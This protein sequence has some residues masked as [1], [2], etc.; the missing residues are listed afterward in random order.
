[1]LLSLEGAT[2]G[3][4]RDK[5]DDVTCLERSAT[6]PE[7]VDLDVSAGVG[8]KAGKG[9]QYPHDKFTGTK[10]SRA[11]I[12]RLLRPGLLG[13]S[14]GPRSLAI[15]KADLLKS[16][17]SMLDMLHGGV[18]FALEHVAVY[19]IGASMI[20]ELESVQMWCGSN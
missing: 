2:R 9:K 13:A 5:Q 7:T 1:M 4:G 14:P 11:K 15:F 6:E 8:K 20:C 12:A 19:E 17:K 10:Q 3:G 16:S 18:P